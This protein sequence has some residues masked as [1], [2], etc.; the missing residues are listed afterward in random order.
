MKV[1]LP[2]CFIVITILYIV[3]YLRYIHA[4]KDADPIKKDKTRTV[5]N[6]SFICFCII[7]VINL[8]VFIFL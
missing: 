8:F 6:I 5:K 1:L 7:I 3:N 4:M 2:I